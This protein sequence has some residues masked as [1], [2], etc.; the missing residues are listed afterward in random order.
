MKMIEYV[1]CVEYNP[2]SP[3]ANKLGLKNF[4]RA[5]YNG[6]SIA[7]GDTKKECI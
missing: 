6:E 7:Y 4:W 2:Y 1:K 3:K 5:D